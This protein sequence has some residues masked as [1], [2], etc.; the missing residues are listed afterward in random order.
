MAKE[1]EAEVVVASAP[2]YHDVVGDAA[3]GG[4][5]DHPSPS[6][7]GGRQSQRVAEIDVDAFLLLLLW[8]LRFGR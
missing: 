7:A 1:L 3:A 5:T 4:E 2:K 6:L 8:V